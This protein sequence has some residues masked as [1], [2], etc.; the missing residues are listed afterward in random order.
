MFTLAVRLMGMDVYVNFEY[1]P[2]DLRPD[3][4]LLAFKQTKQMMT[5]EQLSLGLITDE[6]ASL[7]LTGKLPPAGY[8]PLSG[9]MFHKSGGAQA[10]P[11]AGS[12]YGGAT[13]DGSAMNKNLKSDQP[14]TARGK[15]KSPGAAT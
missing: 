1:E 10:D 4:E 3:N 8:K 2:I 5:L 13:N 11:A 7:I 14:D 15:N 9:T 12:N 6:E